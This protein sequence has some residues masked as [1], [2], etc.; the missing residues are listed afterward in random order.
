MSSSLASGIFYPEQLD[1]GFKVLEPEQVIFGV[2]AVMRLMALIPLALV[3]EYRSVQLRKALAY[4][5][6][7]VIGWRWRNEKRS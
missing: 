5:M 3:R 6:S 2:G 1:L 4:T 7:R